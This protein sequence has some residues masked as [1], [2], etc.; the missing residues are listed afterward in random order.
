MGARLPPEGYRVAA[1]R[2]GLPVRMRGPDGRRWQIAGA[3]VVAVVASGCSHITGSSSS[4]DSKELTGTFVGKL[5]Q[6]ESTVATAD[7]RAPDS[8]K[9]T[10]DTAVRDYV[11]NVRSLRA[12][13]PADLHA[14]LTRVESD[15]Q[16]YRFEA[17]RTDRA[18]LDA[19]A[20]R[21]C[22]R[23]ST[24]STNTGASVTTT[25]TAPSTG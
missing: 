17:A 6:I 3:V 20:A 23:S 24:A 1:G 5:D 8:F 9:Q 21:T 2:Y 10:L 12:I 25:T 7:V 16:Q 13:A 4:K 22:G 15:V 14:G 19:Y 18:S 11:S